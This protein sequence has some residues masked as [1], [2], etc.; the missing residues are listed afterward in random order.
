MDEHIKDYQN[1]HRV[2]PEQIGTYDE[3]EIDDLLDNKA[4]L[5]DGKVPSSQLPDPTISWI[6]VE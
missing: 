5:V 2:T 6:E 1:P 4:D 3:H